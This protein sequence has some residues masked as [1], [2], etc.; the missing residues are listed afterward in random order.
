MPRTPNTTPE[1]IVDRNG[2][3]TTVHR[4]N[5][6]AKTAP[7][8][9]PSAPPAAPDAT[10][11]PRYVLRNARDVE[12]GD[13]IWATDEGFVVSRIDSSYKEQRGKDA[14]GRLFWSA[15][16]QFW[17]VKLNSSIIVLRDEDVLAEVMEAGEEDRE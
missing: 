12:V 3:T 13:V 9:L 2:K 10:D 17:D 15:S 11:S 14:E 8:Q 16:G 7:T 1:T 5:D 6:R 4:K